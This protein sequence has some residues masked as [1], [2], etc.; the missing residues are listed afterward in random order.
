MLG[1]VCVCVEGYDHTGSVNELHVMPMTQESSARI[2]TDSHFYGV[3]G[4]TST[5]LFEHSII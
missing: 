1:Q 3:N 4:H 5:D 2:N